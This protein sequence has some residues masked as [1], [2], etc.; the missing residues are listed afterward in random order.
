MVKKLFSTFFI[1]FNI[2]LVLANSA[3]TL[4]NFR[5]EDANKNRVYFD[6]SEPITASTVNGFF[7]TEKTVTGVTINAGQNT[8]HY[9]TVS[10]PF[11]FWDNN[12]IR[13]EGNGSLSW[14]V[15][16]PSDMQDLDGNK[17]QDFTL[18]YI[19]NNIAEPETTAEKF[20]TPSATGGG[21]GNSEATA[22]T[23]AEA[24]ANATPGTTVWMKAG[25][26]GNIM[27]TVTLDGTPTQPIKF[28]GYKD[29]TGDI[30]SN[31]RY[32]NLKTTPLNPSEM[33]TMTGTFSAGSQFGRPI[34]FAGAHYLIFR[35]LQLR[36]Y[37]NSIDGIANEN[38]TNSHIIFDAINSDD[39][40]QSTINVYTNKSGTEHPIGSN[41]MR[42]LNS[43]MT[44]YEMSA[45]ALWGDGSCLIERVRVYNDMPGRKPD[46]QIFVS[47]DY[48]IIRNCEIEISRSA[49]G[50]ST[51]GFGVR[52][53]Q[54]NHN[55]Y[56]LIEKN[57]AHNI[58]ESFYIR[59]DGSYYNVI[60]DCYADEGDALPSDINY[61]G[62]VWLWGG[63]NYNVV[64]RVE[65]YNMQY[66]IGFKDNN[67]EPLNTYVQGHDNVIRNS[68]FI[69]CFYGI[70]MEGK[71]PDI[72][73]VRNNKIINCVFDNSTNNYANGTRLFRYYYTEMTDLEIINTHIEGFDQWFLNS[74]GYSA[75]PSNEITFTNVNYY[76]NTPSIPSGVTQVGTL[77]EVPKFIDQQ[78][79]NYQLSADSPLVGAGVTRSEVIFD[80]IGNERT[81]GNYSIGAYEFI[82]PFTGSVTPDLSICEGESTTLAASGGLSYEWNTGETTD[83]LTVSPTETTTYSVTITDLNNITETLDV[84]VT[85]DTAPSVDA[86]IDQ[87]ICEGDS[88]TLTATGNG[89]F[90][91][92]TGE[93]TESITVSPTATTTYTVTANNACN[94]EVSDEVVVTVDPSVN[95]DAGADVIICHGESATLTASGTGPFS[96]STG[97]STVSITVNPS[98]TTTYTVTSTNGTCTETDEVIVTVNMPPSVDAGS[99]QTICE[100]DI[101]ILTATGNGDF[102]WSTGETTPSITVSPASTTTYT[103]TA[104]NSCS[105]EVS[106]E[107]VV[108]VD[109]SV[110]LNAGD[111]VTICQSDNITLTATGT[112]PFNWSTGE[113]TASITV[114][115]SETTTY[116]V[117]ST[118]GACSET[119]EVMVMVNN[120]PSADAGADQTIC[121]GDS[122]ILTA[123]G[124]GDFLWSTGETT[125]SIT[126]SPSATT[127]YSVTV[128]NSC[129][130]DATDDVTVTVNPGIT[131]DAGADVSVC[132]GDSVTLTATGSGPFNW[133][134]GE[135]T[136]SITVN[137]SATTTYTVVSDNGFCSLTDHVQVTV[138][139]S[140][141][142]NAGS[143][144]TICAGQSVTL[145][146]TGMSDFLWSTGETTASITVNPDET[147][148]YSVTA[149]SS[150]C[151]STAVDYVQVTVAENP[152]LSTSGDV[153]IQ[154]GES[155]TLSATGAGSFFWSNGATTSSITVSPTVTTNYVVTLTNDAGCS[156]K[157]LIRV[158]VASG[159]G[160][161]GVVAYAG[162][163]ITI[164]SGEKITLSA[165]GG[166]DFLW[167]NGETGRSIE[168]TPE[169]S[170]IYS[171]RVTT[172]DYTDTAYVKV[173]IDDSCSLSEKEMIIYPNP[174]DG[175]LNV[176]LTNFEENSRL[177]LFSLSGNMLFQQNVEN[178]NSLEKTNLTLDL[179]RFRKG[180]YFLRVVSKGESRLKKVILK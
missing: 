171:V 32:D 166:D 113:T 123:V 114:S 92:S 132:Q 169:E 103:V 158:T 88:I 96:W 83:I 4:S 95:L 1:L 65:G 68:L 144:R 176:T 157:S 153:T 10:S 45:V 52:G 160:P 18:S 170:T 93:T 134:T 106:D 51:H 112:G 34:Y 143:D 127:T 138:N 99:D 90:L 150:G 82:N 67:E 167:S 179:S 22:W 7:I 163:D 140:P 28:I 41:N 35:N 69:N 131:L 165:S 21:D 142:V 178:E 84:T 97:E 61:R 89:D 40:L 91:W 151:Q 31:Y 74:S 172:G 121:E 115:P 49:Q 129:S 145:T 133:S 154:E 124:N 3:P 125:P 44:N 75:P 50:A 78:N 177:Y 110:N 73:T 17:L 76:N 16:N 2:F 14:T 117:T 98:E 54:K 71:A 26:Y 86:G 146:A 72:S 12:T 70:S 109:P 9:F 139:T 29:T 180:V 105:T 66:G 37:S 120:P 20:V 107:V 53:T 42:V 137:P 175:L 46:Y 159:A 135:T 94:T 33:P 111:D 5:V 48:N 77:N 87:T 152:V 8:G 79:R 147:T 56:N 101:I 104:S 24:V 47:G 13:Y 136:A 118:N 141:F 148:T 39:M 128:T 161:A 80:F 43:T 55:Y 85:V 25:D 119:D 59:N 62:L 63:S 6:S 108:T 81:S 126:V 38:L 130:A 58:N 173:T 162:E 102:L 30:T 23:M 174:T 116:S 149:S 15:N 122:V 156:E 36:R 19:D 60:K 168:V 57:V 27:F 164:C 64:E 100:G 155:V 11:N